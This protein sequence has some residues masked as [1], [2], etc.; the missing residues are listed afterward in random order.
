MKPT[1]PKPAQY[2]PYR[3]IGSRANVI[4]DGA[5]L[6]STI[7]TLS[8]W[9]NNATPAKL[10][11][12]TSTA[13]VFAYLEDPDSHCDVGLV[14]N[15]HF[16]ED[17]LFSMFGLISPETA[18]ANRELLV[19]ASFAGDFGVYQ[20]RAAARLCFAIESFTAEES[21]PLPNSTFLGCEH[22]RVAALYSEML[23][24][25][26]GLLE[27]LDEY[28]EYWLQQD[29]HLD[30]S[31]SLIASGRIQIDEI[32]EFDL[33][34]VHIP[35][36]LP[37]REV[38]RYL[39]SESAPVHPFAIHGVTDSNRILRVQGKRC[40]LQYRYESW[41]QLVSRRPQLRAD[42]RSLCERLNTME[43]AAGLWRCDSVD[44]IS[45]RMYLEGTRDTAI[46]IT[47]LIG[48]ICSY[49]AEAPVAWDPYDWRAE[50]T[51]APCEF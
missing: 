41:V 4:V 43:K 36:E 37:S 47:I 8:H 17:G 46:P 22:Q 29:Q 50:Q 30:E 26:P 28:R 42:L 20:A 1:L 12:D 6:K 13:T 33:A 10:K 18:M 14:S 38:R 23:Q 9:P 48:E 7:L 45:P 49:L 39:Q 25:L 3:K 51:D 16:D 2:V 19:D 35:A 24:R 21:S 34:I 15:N 27:N 31:E 11:R 40:E 5:P 32:P 44:G